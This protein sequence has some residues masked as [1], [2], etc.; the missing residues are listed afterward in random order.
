MYRLRIF[1]TAATAARDWEE[2]PLNPCCRL[3]IFET[4][5][6]AAW[7]WE[8]KPLNPCCR[9]RIF[10]TA[11]TAAL[12]G[13]SVDN[14]RPAASGSLKQRRLRPDEDVFA[15]CEINH[16]LRIFETAATAAHPL[17]PSIWTEIKYGYR[18]RNTNCSHAN[19]ST[20]I[21]TTYECAET[22]YPRDARAS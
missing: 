18:E 6:T 12:Q 20:V 9:L 11:A 17:I 10:E 21:Y 16:R 19:W 7:D 13:N 22:I 4:A 14:D 15:Y 5:A 2:K 3:R 1:E 8:E